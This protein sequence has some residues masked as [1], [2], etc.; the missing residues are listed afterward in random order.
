[1]VRAFELL[2]TLSCAL[3]AGAAIYVNLVEHPARMG[4]GTRLAAT[5]WAPSYARATVMQASLAIVSALSGVAAWFLGGG[6]LWAVG[7]VLI[8]LV[9]PF[10][11]VA[12]MP[13]NKQLLAPGRDLESG[14]THALLEKWAKL[15][16]VRSVLS[17]AA[18]LV[19]IWSL[20]GA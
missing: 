20:L 5:V 9:V 17:F 13:T 12:I 4:C 6:P 2:A 19:F 14:E 15:H 3:F 10:T 1:M 16:A 18:T 7:A 8:G 11:F